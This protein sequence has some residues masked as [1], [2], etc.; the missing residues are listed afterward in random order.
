MKNSI[1]PAIGMGVTGT[2]WTDREAMTITRISPSGKTFWATLDK[3]TRKPEW[4]PEIIPGGFAGHCVNN[5]SQE[6]DYEPQ[7]DGPERCFK[8]NKKG[9]W[10]CRKSYSRVTLGKRSAFYDYHF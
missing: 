8:L 5:S 2:I 1:T 3:A 9:E 7:P 10:T 6:Y 4:K